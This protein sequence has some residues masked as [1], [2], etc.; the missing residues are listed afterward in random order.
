MTTA[1]PIRPPK[2]NP[3]CL[4]SSFFIPPVIASALARS[5]SVIARSFAS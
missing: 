5:A 4:S 2:I 1:T 3:S